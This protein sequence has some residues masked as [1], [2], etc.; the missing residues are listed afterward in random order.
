MSDILKGEVENILA[1]IVEELARA[2]KLHKDFNSLHE[3]YA[4][5]L[6]ELDEVWD[7]VKMR[8]PNTSALKKELV[9]VAAMCIK[10]IL[11]LELDKE[12]NE[13]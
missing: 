9:Q 12:N 2:N 5:I 8:Y 1:E 13:F 6:E 7:F 3:A 4:V 11:N 10:A